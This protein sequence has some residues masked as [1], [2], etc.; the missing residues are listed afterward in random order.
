M[1]TEL[2]DE[3]KI[4]TA[5]RQFSAMWPFDAQIQQYFGFIGNGVSCSVNGTFDCV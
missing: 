3:P 5:F 4:L 1:K 2:V